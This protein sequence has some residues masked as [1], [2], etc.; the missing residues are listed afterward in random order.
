M[1]IFLYTIILSMLAFFFGA[2]S[3]VIAENW[4]QVALLWAVAPSLALMESHNVFEV[5]T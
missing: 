3:T 4:W 5:G 2:M 1:R